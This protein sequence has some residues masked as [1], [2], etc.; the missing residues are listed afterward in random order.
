MEFK[1]KMEQQDR[2]VTS[3]KPSWSLSGGKLSRNIA[4]NDFEKVR[5][6]LNGLL[7]ETVCFLPRYSLTWP[8]CDNT[9][10]MYSA[11]AREYILCA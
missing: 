1:R 11:T 9:G 5:A 6:N 2:N 8:L 7:E 4:C 10:I 3:M